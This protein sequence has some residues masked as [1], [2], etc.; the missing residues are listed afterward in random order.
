MSLGYTTKGLL[1]SV[2]SL[3]DWCFK[4]EP[5]V[6][7][8]RERFGLLFY[9]R[10]GPKLTFLFSGPWIDPEF[11]SGR[12]TLKEWFQQEG[13]E[14]KILRLKPKILRMLARLVDKGLI[15]D[16]LGDA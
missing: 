2:D 3:D 8:R 4:L 16:T 15:V 9:S 7:V 11:F 14:E 13:F 5:G 12:L 6:R 1:E 10:N